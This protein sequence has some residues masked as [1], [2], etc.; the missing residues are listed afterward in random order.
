MTLKKH[1]ENTTA[2]S[3]PSWITRWTTFIA[4]WWK[5]LPKGTRTRSAI[6]R[7]PHM[8]GSTRHTVLARFCGSPESAVSLCSSMWRSLM[9][10]MLVASLSLGG[11]LDAFAQ[12]SPHKHKSKKPKSPPCQTGCKPDTSVPQVAADTPQ[13]EAAQKELSE[14]ARALHSA[15]PGAYERLAAFA[16]KNTTNIWGARAAL[17]LGYDDYA[18]N[19]AVLDRTGAA[20]P[21]AKCG[22][23]Q[24]FT[25]HSA[26]LPQYRDARG[27]AGSLR[28]YCGPGG[29]SAGGHRCSRCLSRNHVEVRASVRTCPRLSG[30][31]SAC[32]R[33]EGLSDSFLQIPVNR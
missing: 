1:I 7:T 10:W 9:T 25:N 20:G 6:I 29:T 2:A 8:R 27:I 24:S 16:G 28:P 19:R 14:L 17:A 3:N 22:R 18:R 4:G 33:R 23:L 15:T 5:S 26:R 21:G 11:A 32:S 12:S 13:D 31:A 30:R